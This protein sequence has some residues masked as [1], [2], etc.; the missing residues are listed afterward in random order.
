MTPYIKAS[1]EAMVND[2]ENLKDPDQFTQKLI[3]LKAQ[4]DEMISY[5]FDNHM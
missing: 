4:I 2:P 3:E 5:S 1:G